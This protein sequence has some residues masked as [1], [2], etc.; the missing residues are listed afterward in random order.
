MSDKKIECGNHGFQ[1]A[2]FVCMHLLR[3]GKEKPVGFYQAE[4]DPNN[5]EWG[6]LNA[7]CKECEDVLER[8]GE[9]NDESEAFA[10]IH[11]VCGECFEEMKKIQNK[12]DIGNT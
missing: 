12:L 4:V 3:N 8:E 10:N 2:A 11:L 6:D 9:W 5:R 7:W 1:E